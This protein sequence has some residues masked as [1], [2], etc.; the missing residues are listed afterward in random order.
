MGILSVGMCATVVCSACSGQQ[1]AL[2]LL[3]LELK[4]V[5]SHHVGARN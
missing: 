3:E 2:G 1:K 5:V 4:T